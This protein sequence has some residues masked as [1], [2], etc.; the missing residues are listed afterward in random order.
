M[1]TIQR[2]GRSAGRPPAGR[3]G[4]PGTAVD[5]PPLA[6]LAEACRRQGLPLT[7]QRR[8]LL[9][10]HS[11][12]EAHP[13]ADELFRAAQEDLPGVSRTTVYRVLETLVELGLARRVSHPGGSVRFDARTDRHHHLICTE[14]GR[15]R[16]LEAPELD[17]LPP[18][19]GLRGFE[20]RDYSVHFSGLCRECRSHER[21]RPSPQK[22]ECK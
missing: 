3:A 22:G 21:R 9:E 15:V 11:A 6:R 17:R 5:G 12:S 7:Q 14:C 2:S 4:A 13:T 20:V 10:R 18:P 16:D 19:G 8:V 1:I